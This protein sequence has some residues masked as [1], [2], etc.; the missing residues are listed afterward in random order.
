M[1][2]CVDC[3]E[4]SWAEVTLQDCV[5]CHPC[6]SKRCDDE[7]RP[8]MGEMFGPTVLMLEWDDLQGHTV[9]DALVMD[10]VESKIKEF[11]DSKGDLT[12]IIGSDIFLN[13]YRLAIVQG[14]I[15]PYHI[16]LRFKGEVYC[17]NRFGNFEDH[18]SGTHWPRGLA[19]E[20]NDIVRDL[21]KRQ[22][23]LRKEEYSERKVDASSPRD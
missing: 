11:S 14:K 20:Q 17:F 21:V 16:M 3:T 23:A 7:S 13:A 15:E 8:A 6:F 10:C 19:S 4:E 9:P 18:W 22:I 1:E 5:L 12:H 2:Q